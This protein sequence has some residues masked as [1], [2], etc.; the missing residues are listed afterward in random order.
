MQSKVV[1]K[2]LINL[3]SML[4]AVPS[5]AMF[6]MLIPLTGLGRNTA[7][8]V[9]VIYNQYIL[10]RNFIT[11]LNEVD[12]TAVD[13]ATGMGMTKMQVF[14]KIRLP[15]SKKTLYAGVR[16]ALVSSIG[17]ATIAALINA[18]GLGAV[19]YDGLRTMNIIRILWG[20]LLSAGLAI[21]VSALLS[22]MEKKL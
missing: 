11:G 1:A 7:I 21:G 14:A 18:G 8:I 6:V 22:L 16:L 15:L 9:L 5:L 20:S 10:L 19:L 12:H 13:A 17:I 2:T 4:H 3:F